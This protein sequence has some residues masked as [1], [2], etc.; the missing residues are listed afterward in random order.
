[1][2]FEIPVLA[3]NDDIHSTSYH[4]RT[5][6]YANGAIFM[7]ECLCPAHL[8]DYKIRYINIWDLENNDFV[9]LFEIVEGC[10]SATS[11]EK[12]DAFNILWAI[13][14]EDFYDV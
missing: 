11:A 7:K 9:R 2:M 4:T 3:L 14:T 6:N 13:G 8:V 5:A 10:V 12:A 1:M